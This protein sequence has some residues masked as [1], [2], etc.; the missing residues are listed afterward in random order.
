MYRTDC[1][2]RIRYHAVG[3]YQ[4]RGLVPT[5]TGG[6]LLLHARH[7]R[8]VPMLSA[9]RLAW[10]RRTRTVRAVPPCLLCSRCAGARGCKSKVWQGELAT[11]ERSIVGGASELLRA[12]FNRF[13]RSLVFWK[14]LVE[15]FFTFY[16]LEG[17]SVF[18]PEI[19]I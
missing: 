18:R 8:Y 3:R 11:L 4:R 2:I 9:L 5:R 15:N 16:M 1:R 7:W 13:G 17:N 10:I 14:G 6:L 19:C 12:V